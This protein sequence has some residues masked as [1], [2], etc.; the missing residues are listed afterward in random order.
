MGAVA[1]AS[2]RDTISIAFTGE[3]YNESVTLD[4]KSFVVTSSGGVPEILSLAVD[5][6]LTFAGE[7]SV[8]SLDL[9]SGTVF[10]SGWLTI[11]SGGKVIRRSAGAILSEQIQYAGVV[12]LEY[13]GDSGMIMGNE[14]PPDSL[15]SV[16]RHITLDF[17]ITDTT[18]ILDLN[19]R[20][21]KVNGVLHLFNGFLRTGP[22]KLILNNPVGQPSV[23]FVRNVSAGA[24][25][26]VIGNVEANLKVGQ[27]YGF[28]WN[29]FPVGD[30]AFYRPASLIFVNNALPSSGISLGAAANVRYDPTPPTGRV[31]LP[32]VDGVA[33]GAD[34]VRYPDFSWSIATSEAI[35]SIQFHLELSAEGYTGFGGVDELSN[36]RIIRRAGGSLD[37]TNPWELQGKDY[38]NFIISGNSSVVA[39]N[40][41]GGLNPTGF[42][43]TYGLRAE[44]VEHRIP[45]P[46]GWNMISSFVA[47]RDSTLDSLYEKIRPNMVLTKNGLGQV[48]WPAFNINTIGN[49]SFRHGYQVY[50]QLADTLVVTGNELIP[51][52]SLLKISSGWNLVPYLRNS[53]MRIDSALV[54][55]GS[56]V[57]IAK[58]NTGEV[59]WPIFGINTIG[60]MKSGAAYQMFLSSASTLYY[61]ANTTSTPSSMRVAMFPSDTI[62]KE[63]RVLSRH[64]GPTR[65][66]TGSSAILLV[67]G[68]DLVDGDEIAAFARERLL[69]SAVVEDGRALLTIWGDDDLTTEGREGAVEDEGILLRVWLKKDQQ[70]S[71][72]RTT[73][74]TD[75]LTGEKAAPVLRYRK[76]AVWIAAVEKGTE[77]P[78]EFFLAQNYPNPFNPTTT[79]RYGLPKTAG[80]T[81]DIFNVL[82]QKVLTIV[83]AEQEAGY[84]TVQFHGGRIASGVYIY[85]ITAGEFRASRKL[86]LMK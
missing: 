82:G 6:T 32:I 64:Y 7:C 42:I 78:N 52:Q 51:Q 71:P 41:T 30:T 8:G 12:D 75:G 44:K 40:S 39:V 86:L 57:V 15:E 2:D 37:V 9:I 66:A 14:V 19:D 34:I 56:S 67:Q 31:G 83:D 48:Y 46:Q 74:L 53:P 50:M 35:G 47:P 43:F 70:D 77:I 11:S 25:S 58:N 4:G 54:T 79:I 73:S 26:H 20:N 63:N 84:Y 61:P 18:P 27:I 5:T 33:P 23:G 38:D 3:L 69:G 85:Q 59:Y 80:V 13:R 62:K 16:V 60:T 72:L 10:G 65:S 55:M 22:N 24:R 76:D 29:S 49:W 68:N 28:G 36:L 81:L 45:L 1:V 17:S 21:L